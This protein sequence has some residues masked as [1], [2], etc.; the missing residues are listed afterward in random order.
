MRKF[1]FDNGVNLVEHILTDN[2]A[3]YDVEF[4]SDD[5]K[6]ITLGCIDAGYAENVAMAISRG[7]ISVRIEDVEL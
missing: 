1:S 5:G 3:V 7:T 2:S 4:P 6:L